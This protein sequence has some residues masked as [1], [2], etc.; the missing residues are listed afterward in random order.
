MAFH[1]ASV[2]DR[3][4]GTPGR[5][6]LKGW[7]Q[8]RALVRGMKG[9]DLPEWVKRA[10]LVQAT[11]SSFTSFTSLMKRKIGGLEGRGTLLVD[12]WED[13]PVYYTLAVMKEP[14][15]TAISGEGKLWGDA[16]ALDARA[17]TRLARLRVR[18][19][20]EVM[21]MLTKTVEG[22]A[23]FVADSGIPGYAIAAQN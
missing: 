21:I 4:R 11:N 19:G 13:L 12:G 14:L 18:G 17:G 2:V 3:G 16:Q 1:R 15:R 20:D 10:A 5:F 8:D 7:P 23:E 22:I 6:P 9:D